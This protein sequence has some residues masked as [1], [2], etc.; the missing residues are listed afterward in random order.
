M[1]FEERPWDNYTVLYSDETCQ[2]KKLVVNPG[3][4]ISLQSHKFRGEHWFILS[5]SGIAEL[6]GKV[7]HLKAGNSIDVPV[8]SLHRISA[9]PNSPL[10]LIEIQTG[11]SFG[12]DDILRFEDDFGRC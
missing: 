6:D 4:H 12:E 10:T 1:N 3:K 8:G 11:L 5:G 9:A 7:M 2:I